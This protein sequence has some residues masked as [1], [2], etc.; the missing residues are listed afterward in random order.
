MKEQETNWTE[1]YA[2]V[3]K[4]V[5]NEARQSVKDFVDTNP[6]VKKHLNNSDSREYAVQKIEDYLS[7]KY[8]STIEELR[9][10]RQ[11]DGS[12]SL[13]RTTL[14]WRFTARQPQ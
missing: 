5:L 1:V 9:Q 6:R 4:E 14:V 3:E 8:D 10:G 13:A 2:R 12:T 11:P 7:R